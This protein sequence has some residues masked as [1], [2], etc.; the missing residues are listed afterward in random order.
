MNSEDSKRIVLAAWHAFKTR[1]PKRVKGKRSKSHG[2]G[3]FRSIWRYR[4]IFWG[5]GFEQWG[6]AL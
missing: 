4:G 3:H 6:E 5:I 1:D 2:N